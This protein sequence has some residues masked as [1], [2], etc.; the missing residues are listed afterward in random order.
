VPQYVAS[1]CS[2][3]AHQSGS[4]E[5]SVSIIISGAKVDIFHHSS[6]DC[7]SNLY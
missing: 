2:R 5:L 1:A 7:F 6:Y 3:F 4:F